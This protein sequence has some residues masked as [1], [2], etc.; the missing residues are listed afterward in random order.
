MIELIVTTENP[1]HSFRIADALA[2]VV[3]QPE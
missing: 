2:D 3:G 1:N